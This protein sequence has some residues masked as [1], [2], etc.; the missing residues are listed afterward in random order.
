MLLSRRQF[1][2]TAAGAATSPGR[3]SPSLENRLVALPIGLLYLQGQFGS[4]SGA[5]MAFALINV[6]PMV[7]VFLVF[8]RYVVQGFSRS[9]LR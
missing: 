1:L 5:T 9:G 4:D 8:Q 7:V 3:S 6:I 2:T